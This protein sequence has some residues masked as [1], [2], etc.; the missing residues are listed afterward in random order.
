[1]AGSKLVL[2]AGAVLLDDGRLSN[3]KVEL[4]GLAIGAGDE[5]DAIVK[6]EVMVVAKAVDALE[7]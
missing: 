4:L 7:T 5:L 3:G 2:K 6:L 1:V